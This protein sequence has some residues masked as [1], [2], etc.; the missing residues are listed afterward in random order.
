MRWEGYGIN[1]RKM[2]EKTAVRI[3][4][5]FFIHLFI[6]LKFSEIKSQFCGKDKPSFQ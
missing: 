1:S 6:T 2:N 4:S 3:D 5:C